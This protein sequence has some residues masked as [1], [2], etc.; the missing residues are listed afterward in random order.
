MENKT[1]VLGIIGL[2]G[3][4]LSILCIFFFGWG[5]LIFGVGGLVCSILGRKNENGKG[6]ATAGMVCSIIGLA[7]FLIIVLII[8]IILASV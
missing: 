8:G 1:N 7:L 3:G 5:T 4:I 6:L 2:V